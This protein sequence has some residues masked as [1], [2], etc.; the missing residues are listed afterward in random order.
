V[1]SAAGLKNVRTHKM[2]L[3]SICCY[4][5]V[6]FVIVYKYLIIFLIHS[7]SGPCIEIMMI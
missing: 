6:C 4:V 2:W 1:I 3:N 5:S 7:G